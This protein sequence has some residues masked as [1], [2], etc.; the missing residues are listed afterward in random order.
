MERVIDVRKGLSCL[1]HVRETI[2]AYAAALS[3]T[4]CVRGT[5]IP[6]HDVARMLANGDGIDEIRDA[7]PVV[8]EEQIDAAAL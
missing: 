7:W 4:P 6:A 8:S 2:I 1:A 5:R 3:G